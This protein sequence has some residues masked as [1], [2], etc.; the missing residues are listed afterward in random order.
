MRA[1]ILMLAGF[2]ALTLVG[3]AGATGI[4]DQSQTVSGYSTGIGEYSLGVTSHAQTFTAGISGSLDQVDLMLR[5][6]EC[7]GTIVV[8]VRALNHDGLPSNEVLGSGSLAGTHVPGVSELRWVSVPLNEPARVVA[9]RQYAIVLTAY[10]GIYYISDA[11]DLDA[12]RDFYSGGQEL[13]QSWISV[14]EWRWVALALPSDMT[15][16]TYVT[17][18]HGHEPGVR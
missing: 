16:K 1:R 13:F 11:L 15:F 10:H 7:T 14:H 2:A 4:I 18:F 6:G 17:A 5:C 9:G 8:E 3:S 12:E